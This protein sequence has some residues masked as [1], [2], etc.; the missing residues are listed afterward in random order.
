[1]SAPDTWPCRV[2]ALAL[3]LAYGLAFGWLCGPIEPAWG[4]AG[5]IVAVAL[6]IRGDYSGGIDNE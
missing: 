4:I 6:T 3:A 1:M 2:H 5:A